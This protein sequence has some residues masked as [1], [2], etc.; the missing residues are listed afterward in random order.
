[1]ATTA[2]IATTDLSQKI[3]ARAKGRTGGIKTLAEGRSDIHKVNPFLIRVED[4][5][6]V[7]DFESPEVAEHV[8]NLAQSIA[9]IGVQRPLKVRNKGNELILKDG[10]CRL[11]ATIRAIEVYG[12]E[13]VAIPVVLA[14][15]SESDADATLGILVEN[16]GL[17]LTVSGKSEIVKRLT[18]FGWSR[19]DIAAKAGMSK[20]RV[21]QLLEFAGLSTEIKGLVSAGTVSATAALATA[22]AHDFDDDKTVEVIK[23]A[24]ATK[25]AA[26]GKARVTARAL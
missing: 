14:D 21:I 25:M 11:R 3:A 17:D 6:N 9:K 10:E 2:L 12:A 5:F 7:R 22:R 1:M 19:E 16:S 15:R 24:S 20:A 13:I 18:A 26:S 8:D 23:S 4:G